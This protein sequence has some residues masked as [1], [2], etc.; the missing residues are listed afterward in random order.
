MVKVNATLLP[1][2]TKAE[3][4]LLDIWGFAR[5]VNVAEA[6]LP[7]PASLDVTAVVVLFLTPVV[8]AVTN[9]ENVQLELDAILAPDRLTAV[10]FA[11]AVIV[12]P[13]QLPLSPFGLNICSPAGKLSVN[14]TPVS[15]VALFG[16]LIV[17]ERVDVLVAPTP[18]V[19]GVNDLEITGADAT[20]RLTLAVVA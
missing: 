1:T 4:K 15:V 11:V 10:E 7:L 19:D 14:P 13:P 12:P 20:V 17:N 3:A 5:T 8:V 18:I 6:V 2:S 16:L 9:T